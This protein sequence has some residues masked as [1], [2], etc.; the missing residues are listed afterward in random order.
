M[1]AF[2]RALAYSVLL[3]HFAVADPV[4][5]DGT[6]FSSVGRNTDGNGLP[7]GIEAAVGKLW[8]PVDLA[9]H[10]CLSDVENVVLLRPTGALVLP[11][12]I[13]QILLWN[14]SCWPTGCNV[15]DGMQETTR[16]AKLSSL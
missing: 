4:S 5:F 3:V 12:G 6:R 14:C 15:T 8:V 7:S 2:F 9:R 16:T 10:V 1:H 13:R 11:S